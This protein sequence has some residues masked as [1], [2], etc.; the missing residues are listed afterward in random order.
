AIPGPMSL[1][2]RLM[3]D[4]DLDPF[5]MGTFGSLTTPMMAPQ[6]R[7]AAAAAR[8]ILIAMAAEQLKVQP[9]DLQIVDARFVNHDK[10]KTL[11]F[12]EVAKGQKLVKVIPENIAITKASDW[13]AAGR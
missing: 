11:T 13:P 3:G 9:A 8:E 7:K 6:L 1:V 4:T 12:A 5:D 10:S 2:H